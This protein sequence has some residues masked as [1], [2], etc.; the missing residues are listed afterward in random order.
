MCKKKTFFV[1]YKDLLN[2]LKARITGINLMSIQFDAQFVK[3][4]VPDVHIER[5]NF[6]ADVQF[7]IDSRTLRAGDIFIALPGVHVDGHTFVSQAL[8]QGAAGII[9]ETAKKDILQKI[10]AKLLEKKLVLLVPDAM[11]AL[12][13]LAVA[14]RSKFNIPVIAITGSVG[15]TST[16][17]MLANILTLNGNTFLVSQGNQNT[18]IGVS[19]NI[20][21]MRPEHQMAI[22]EVGISKR[23][24]MAELSK[25]LRPTTALI[26]TVGHAHME[27]LG[28]LTDIALEK[29]DVFK[30]FTEQS[31]GIING[32]LP[33]LANVAYSHPVIKFGSKTTN[34]IQARKIRLTSTQ[35]SF[36]MKIYKEK[37]QVILNKPHA[38]IVFNA[39]AAT[40]AAQLLGVSHKV[41]VQGVQIPL[42]INGRFE[43]CPLPEQRGV[44]INDCYNANPESMKAALLAFQNIQTSAQKI[45]VL[46]DMLELGVNS[47]FW[48]RQLGRFLRKVPSLRQVILVGDMV[49]WTKKT[50]PVGVYIE[51]VPDW[52]SA[53]AILENRLDKESLVLVKG[54]QGMGLR[55]LVTAF[56]QKS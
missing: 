4:A 7:S 50:A 52:A 15:K 20:L 17:E 40:A 9:I 44:I 51:M 31:I 34:Q 49:K 19:L 45:A 47:P 38:G 54:S 26:T 29:R 28:S 12:I 30:S 21:K 23:G 39:L 36:V 5:N 25:L 8:K 13:Q 43:Q 53:V 41:I 32:D 1:R 42:A 16:K 33:I 37:H 48:H 14:W 3:Q 35:A 24:E 22:L 11:Q 56:T 55:N 10:D 46:G 27:G 2:N 6:P 18:K